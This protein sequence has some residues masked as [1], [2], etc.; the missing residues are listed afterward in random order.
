MS[1]QVAIFILPRMMREI[2]ESLSLTQIQLYELS[3]ISRQSISYYET[4]A[5]VPNLDSAGKWLNAITREI[6]RLKRRGV[7]AMTEG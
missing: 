1:E 7:R 2:R 6:R 4:G 3:G 5:S